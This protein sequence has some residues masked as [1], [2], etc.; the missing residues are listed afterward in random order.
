M[1]GIDLLTLTTISGVWLTTFALD[2]YHRRMYESLLSAIVL[3]AIYWTLTATRSGAPSLIGLLVWLAAFMVF[4]WRAQREIVPV[5]VIEARDVGPRILSML[6]LLYAS[7]W[8]AELLA[9][10]NPTVHGI[11]TIPFTLGLVGLGLVAAGRFGYG[12]T[13]LVFSLI[14]VPLA[15]LALKLMGW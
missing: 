2:L 5:E 14:T 8:Y 9:S 6:L 10:L 15:L 3:S 7:A 11:V 12:V 13:C 1:S 4:H